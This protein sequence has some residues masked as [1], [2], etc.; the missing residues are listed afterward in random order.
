MTHQQGGFALPMFRDFVPEGWRFW[1]ILI[2]PIVFQMSDAVFMG[3]STQISSDLS[4][5]S[6]DI[7]MCGFA[8]MIGVTMTFPLLFRLK[9]RFTTRLTSTKARIPKRD[10]TTSISW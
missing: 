9:F 1:L 8:G 5:L 10:A 6:E 7:L 3:L 4:L 2:Y